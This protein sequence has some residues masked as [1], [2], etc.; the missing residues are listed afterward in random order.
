MTKDGKIPVISATVSSRTLYFYNPLAS[1]LEGINSTIGENGQLR[2]DGKYILNITD[3]LQ[4]LIL[5]RQLP[6]DQQ[7]PDKG[8]ILA[9][10]SGTPA[11]GSPFG[12]N[13]VGARGLILGSPQ[14]VVKPLK[15]VVY[16]T[17]VNAN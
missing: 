7:L 5:N 4:R 6:A 13:E 9:V 11:S 16:Y 17:Y 12:P 14:N 1:I 3:Y 15:L 10:P 8:L 2:S